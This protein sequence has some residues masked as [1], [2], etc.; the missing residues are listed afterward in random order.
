[1][2]APGSLTLC[3]VGSLE[4][5][6]EFIDLEVEGWKGKKKSQKIVRCRLSAGKLAKFQI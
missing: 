6:V 2:E 3:T 5:G 4:V 1:V